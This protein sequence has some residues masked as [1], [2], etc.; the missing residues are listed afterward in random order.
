MANNSNNNKSLY[1]LYIAL[2]I[3]DHLSFTIDEPGRFIISI[4]SRILSS[5][6]LNSCFA[7]SKNRDALF[8]S[9]RKSLKNARSPGLV[10]MDSFFVTFATTN[11][12]CLLLIILFTLLPLPLQVPP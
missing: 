12:L 5:R 2:A 10:P 9:D 11:G 8:N 6:M 4:P 1:N 3:Q 7:R